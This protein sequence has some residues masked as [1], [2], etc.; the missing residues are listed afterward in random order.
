MNEKNEGNSGIELKDETIVELL[1]KRSHLWW[2]GIVE[3][4]TKQNILNIM[5]KWC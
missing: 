1:K 5:W 2:N 3:R 4:R